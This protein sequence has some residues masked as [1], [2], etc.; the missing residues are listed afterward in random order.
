MPRLPSS[1]DG[2]STREAPESL[3]PHPPLRRYY[4]NEQE[5]KRQVNTWFD[6]SASHYDS[7]TQAM[8]LGSGH[9]YRKDA[10]VRAGLAEGMRMIDVACG[11]GVIA[12]HAQDI[13]GAGGVAI[14]TDRSG[15]M[16]R[17]ARRRG[18][19]W[20]VHATAENLPFESEGF[21]FLS[22]GYALRHVTDL[23]ATFREYRRVLRPGGKVLVLEITPPR[24][25]L[26]FLMLKFYMGRIVPLAARLGRGGQ[27]A[28]EL[29]EYYWDTIENCV[30]PHVILEAFK[31][32]G[33]SSAERHVVLGIFSEYVAVR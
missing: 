31:E 29:M 25:R 20:L 21:D 17:E 23:H 13:V 9:R 2:G 10:L 11:T 12:A 22:M 15:G 32:A 19:R 1:P 5:R 4:S 24:S 14:G 7:I 26:S 6:E 3:R 28:Q 16:L 30:P 33:F 8:S 27:G 18:V